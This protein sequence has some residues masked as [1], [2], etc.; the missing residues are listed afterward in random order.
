MPGI[1]VVS[2]PKSGINRR[3]PQLA[4]DLA[5]ILGEKGQLEQPDRVDHLVA[6]AERF[7]ERQ[8]DILCVNG[9]DGTLH[10]VLSAF[11]QVYGEAPLPKLGLLRAGTINNV[12]R[13]VGLPKLKPEALLGRIVSRYHDDAHFEL[14]ERNLVVVDGQHAGFLFGNGLISSFMETYYEG[15]T[16]GTWKAIRV[17]SRTVASALVGGPFIQR[18]MRP[19]EARVTVDGKVWELDRFLSIGVATIPNMGLGFRPFHLIDRYPDRIQLIGWACPVTGIVQ[20]MPRYFLKRP[21]KRPDIVTDV[22]SEITISSEQPLHFQID[23]DFHQGGTTQHL[24]VGPR[25][26]LITG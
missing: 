13:S 20:A 25:V 3:R 26:R 21:S 12:A 15:G 22:A 6:V 5:Y 1:G 2:N 16:V 19:V 14:V 18:L 8:I 24:R 7:R 17:L 4:N 11:L 10:K 23:G 9:G